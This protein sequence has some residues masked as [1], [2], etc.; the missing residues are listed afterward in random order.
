MSCPARA[1]TPRSPFGSGAAAP[2]SAARSRAASRPDPYRASRSNAVSR[3]MIA[4]SSGGAP[5]A[6]ATAGGLF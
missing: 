4:S 6:A 1:R 5:A 3:A 2:S